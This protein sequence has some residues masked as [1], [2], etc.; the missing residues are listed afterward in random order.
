MPWPTI[1]WGEPKKV[2]L[3]EKAT[4]VFSKVVDALRQHWATTG[5]APNVILLHPDDIELLTSLVNRPYPIKANK[6]MNIPVRQSADVVQGDCE[7]F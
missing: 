5:Q 4:A 3:M 1:W 2:S 7:L 6:F